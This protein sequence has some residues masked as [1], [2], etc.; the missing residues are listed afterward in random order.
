MI[1]LTPEPKRALLVAVHL[2]EEPD[3]E[4]N[5]SVAELGRLAVTLGY[6]VAG[7]VTQRR[8]AFS[9]G[10]Y[11]GPG[12]VDELKERVAAGEA[13]VL[14]VD[15]EIS[16]SQ[17]RNLEK[18]TGAQVLDRT[19]VILEIFHQHAHTR[20]A[21]AQVEIVRL[22]YM[23]PRLREQQKNQGRQRSVVGGRGVGESK[24]ELD[25]RKI[26]DRVTELTEQLEDMEEERRVR[27]ARRQGLPRAALV[28]Y[29]NAGK[30]TLMRALTGAEV[31]V[32]D[33]LFA[34]LDTTVRALHPESQ[35]RILLSDTVGV[36]KK[37][38]HELVASFRST[39]EEALEAGLLIQVVD[40][41]G[42]ALERQLE[43]TNQV[44]AEVGAAQI[45][46]MLVFNKADLL[47]DAAAQAEAAVNLR[48]RW[49]EA[50]VVSARRP[51]DVEH[52]RAA[53]IAFFSRDLIDW[54]LR[55]TYDR[56]Y[57]RPEIHAAGDVLEERYEPGGIL[58]RV[59]L[60]PAALER[61]LPLLHGPPRGSE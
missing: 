5:E 10:A 59:R 61:L 43:T 42:R 40:A 36:I 16:P 41:S 39:L 25:R 14:I 4:F 49:P 23:A 58:L 9:P 15:H 48:R 24:L 34:T 7:A 11:I 3:E 56:Q 30:S 26:R 35:P 27:R 55:L 20:T 51:E 17:A 33:Q 45:P 60:N 19:A 44:L 13:L 38:P 12:K 31:L 21:R 28:G 53:L 1:D 37:L 32:A 47:G 52:V 57:L 29:T 18:E 54:D 2:R 8:A 22:Q 50:L 46:R 6:E